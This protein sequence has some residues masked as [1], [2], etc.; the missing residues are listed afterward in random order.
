MTFWFLNF[1]CLTFWFFFYFLSFIFWFL[2]YFLNFKLSTFFFSIFFSF[3]L[4]IEVRTALSMFGLF[5]DAIAAC[6]KRYL[7]Y[8]EFWAQ[9]EREA[10]R[11][12]FEGNVR[13]SD[14][15]I[16]DH[17]INFPPNQGICLHHPLSD[18][19]QDFLHKQY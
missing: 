17:L 4:R 19:R 8:P 7:W 15:F 16:P 6:L 9:I 11:G 1:W 13:R 14:W 10:E 3:L 12:S 18:E 2:F 5:L